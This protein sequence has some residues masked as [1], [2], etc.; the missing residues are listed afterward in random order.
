MSKKQDFV[1][2][3]FKNKNE[4][5]FVNASDVVKQFGINFP[6]REPLVFFEDKA[7]KNFLKYICIKGELDAEMLL[8][9]IYEKNGFVSAH[10][11]PVENDTEHHKLQLDAD[12]KKYF[13]FASGVVAATNDLRTQNTVKPCD[14]KAQIF[15]SFGNIFPFVNHLVDGRDKLTGQFS[16]EAIK[17]LLVMR[18][19]DTASFNSDRHISN[20]FYT[21]DNSSGQEVVDGI[22]TFDYGA[23]GTI[24]GGYFYNNFIVGGDFQYEKSLNREQML[25]SFKK[26]ETVQ[27]FLPKSES[28]EILG[29]IN[30]QKEAKDLEEETGYHVGQDLVDAWAKSF[31]DMAEELSQ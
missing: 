27:M 3:Y 12:M 20:F 31:D 11:Y 6:K 5:G 10:Y 19:L 4:H 16:D 8:S 1:K 17:Q 9:R 23:S 28:S 7:G 22:K 21:V 13:E 2:F 29:N 15:E 30:F 24:R 14:S 26:N 25:D 18:L